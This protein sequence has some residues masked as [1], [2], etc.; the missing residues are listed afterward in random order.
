MYLVKLSI[1][2]RYSTYRKHNLPRMDLSSRGP[3]DEGPADGLPLGRVRAW[4]RGHRLRLLARQRLA[5]LHGLAG[6]PRRLPARRCRRRQRARRREEDAGG[7][8]VAQAPYL[9]AD[10]GYGA[11]DRDDA[12][13][14]ALLTKALRCY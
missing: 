12:V 9:G 1:L 7:R 6:R 2:D 8:R 5:V 4:G 3:D 11:L 10:V 13:V 14:R